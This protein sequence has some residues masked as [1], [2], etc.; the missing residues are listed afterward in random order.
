[1]L[2]LKLI[3]ADKDSDEAYESKLDSTFKLIGNDDITV[4]VSS[5][6]DK[7]DGKPLLL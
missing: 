3:F 7:S 6:R 1:M 4:V 2:A 5:D